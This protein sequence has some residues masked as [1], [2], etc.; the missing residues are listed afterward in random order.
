METGPPDEPVNGGSQE[1]A[2]VKSEDVE[3]VF[4][5]ENI[6]GAPEWLKRAVV[7]VASGPFSGQRVQVATTLMIIWAPSSTAM[8]RFAMPAA[9][10]PA[11]IIRGRLKV[12]LAVFSWPVLSARARHERS[13]KFVSTML[14]ALAGSPRLE[15]EVRSATTGRSWTGKVV[16]SS[17]GTVVVRRPL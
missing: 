16:A 9:I 12:R 2:T 7:A 14:N 3:E 1:A 13:E 10:K 15:V 6:E 4:I 17:R 8:E 5:P 11:R